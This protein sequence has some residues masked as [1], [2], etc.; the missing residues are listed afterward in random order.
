MTHDV[1]EDELRSLL[2]GAA[3]RQSDALTDVDTAAVLGAGHRVVRRR[4]VARTAG[5]VAAALVVGSA[6]WAALD[7]Q[8]DRSA[9]R[10]PATR[11]AA[12]V[13]GPVT[14]V[15]DEF[16]DLS[17]PDGEPLPVPGPRQVAVRVAPGGALEYLEVGA[18]GATSLLG[19]STL[20]GV[21]PSG[22]T[23]TVVGDGGHV[24]VGVLPAQA[25]VLQ[26]VTPLTDEGGH[27]WTTVRG[28]LPGTGLQAFALRFAA[29]SDAAGVRHLLW[30]AA[31]GTVRDESGA[32]VPS[33]A[34]GDADDTVLFVAEDLGRFGTF[35]RDGATLT[36]LA[37]ARNSS[38]RPVLAT[39]R[40]DGG[41][42]VG[43]FAAVVPAA[44]EAGTMTPRAG[45]TVTHPLTKVPLPRTDLAVLWAAWSEPAGTDG[46][47]YA[48]VTWTEDGRTVTETP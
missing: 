40:G 45:T 3:D 48:S 46:A 32:A 6:T 34:L 39:G 26:P 28:D 17:G 38:G 33:V 19:T 36:E 8:A 9:P 16:A 21:A 2:H 27:A 13:A 44:A 41:R 24:L 43:L 30:R 18:D 22:P 4:R 47:G 12:P 10:I 7:G 25:Q 11:P 15:L 5:A 29:A 23:W 1:F 31:D 35:G 37:G 20:D 14:A 42:V